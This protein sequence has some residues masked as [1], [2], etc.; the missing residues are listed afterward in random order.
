M[1]SIA[2]RTIPTDGIFSAVDRSFKITGE[3]KVNDIF[4]ISNNTSGIGDNRNILDMIALQEADITGINSGSFQD[5]F[6]ATLTEIGSSVRSGEM[7][8]ESAQSS[9]DASKALED[10]RSGVSMDEE[11]SALIEFQQAYSANARIIQTARELFDSL[12]SV[13]RS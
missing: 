2:T 6:N 13:I 7:T 8:L 11:A 10:E 1:D 12:L 4:H 9:R 3:S 5:I